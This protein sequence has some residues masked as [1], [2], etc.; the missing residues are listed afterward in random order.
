MTE[1]A[2]PVSKQ[3]EYERLAHDLANT[4]DWPTLQSLIRGGFWRNFKHK[5]RETDEMYARMMHVSQ[6]LEQATEAG[7]EPNLLDQARDHLYRG[8]CNCPYWHGAFGGV[9]LPHL[10]N[11]IYQHL[12]IAD[13]LLDQATDASPARIEAADFDF[14]LSTEVRAVE[15]RFDRLVPSHR[16]R[17]N[18]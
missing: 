3:R 16:R 5:Y 10:R 6:R 17:S 4:P 1:W 2:L 8:Q 9:Y 12:I 7:C 18:V 13:Q 11:A 15:Y 14:D